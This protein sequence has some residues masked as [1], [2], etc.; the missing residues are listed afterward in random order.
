LSLKVVVT[1]KKMRRIARI[2]I[3][4][5][6]VIEGIFLRFVWNRMTRLKYG[7]REIR[8]A[9]REDESAFQGESSFRALISRPIGGRMETVAP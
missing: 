6:I 4:E 2:S 3:S 7:N 8:K 5:T 1:M 9:L